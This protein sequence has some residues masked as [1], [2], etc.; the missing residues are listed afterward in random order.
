MT[1][2]APAGRICAGADVTLSHV[3]YLTPVVAGNS[4]ATVNGSTPP[5]SHSMWLLG[6]PHTMEAGFQE[7]AFPENQASKVTYHDICYGHNPPRFKRREQSLGLLMGEASVPLQDKHVEWE[8][9]PFLKTAVYP[10]LSFHWK[11]REDVNFPT[12]HFMRGHR[13][14]AILR[15]LLPRRVNCSYFLPFSFSSH[16]Q[17]IL[18]LVPRGPSQKPEYHG[19]PGP[20]NH[21]GIKLGHPLPPDSALLC[22]IQY[23]VLGGQSDLFYQ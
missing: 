12:L 8:M 14:R 11:Q 15:P 13:T 20:K 6:L 10:T 22:H 1:S 2:R 9:W 21:P 16:P 18:E 19:H 23:N 4:A 5:H 3:W 17:K 7:W